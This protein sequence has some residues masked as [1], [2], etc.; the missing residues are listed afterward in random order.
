VRVNQIG[1]KEQLHLGVDRRRL[2]TRRR[3]NQSKHKTNLWWSW[4]NISKARWSQIR[5]CNI[6]K[7][8][9]SQSKK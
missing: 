6:R 8:K 4:Q 7:T 9:L 5:E 3:K 2:W 1:K